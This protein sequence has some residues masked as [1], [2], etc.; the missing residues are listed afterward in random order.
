MAAAVV[1]VTAIAVGAVTYHVYKD[2]PAPEKP[3]FELNDKVTQ[4]K[5]TSTWRKCT[6]KDIEYDDCSHTVFGYSGHRRKVAELDLRS[7][8]EV[9]I[10]P[11]YEEAQK[12]AKPGKNFPKAGVATIAGKSPAPLGSPRFVAE[13]PEPHLPTEQHGYT[14][15]A[16]EKVTPERDQRFRARTARCFNEHIKPVL[17]ILSKSPEA[18]PVSVST[19]TDSVSKHFEVFGGIS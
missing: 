1:A 7:G 3:T 15:I 6:Q 17:T 5:T 19:R 9:W 18:A 11:D 2:H 14:T 4:D 10:T 12:Y 13:G 16:I 8:R